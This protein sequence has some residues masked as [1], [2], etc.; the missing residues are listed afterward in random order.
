MEFE[1]AMSAAEA[2]LTFTPRFIDP[3][4]P[5]GLWICSNAAEVSAIEINAVCLGSGC[6]WDDIVKTQSFLDHFPFLVIVTPNAI[7]RYEMD[8]RVL[9]RE[10]LEE[11]KGNV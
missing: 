9:I 6:E 3:N 4:M 2:F 7:A 8:E 10:I 1:K 5:Q 11:S